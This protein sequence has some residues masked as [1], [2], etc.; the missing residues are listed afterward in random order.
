M[1]DLELDD[2]DDD[3]VD[4]CS[5]TSNLS[6]QNSINLNRR[7]RN[8]TVSEIINE[9]LREANL[10]E[11]DDASCASSTVSRI[12][13]KKRVRIRLSKNEYFN[14][15]TE[16][17]TTEEIDRA[18]WSVEDYDK[19]V[20]KTQD[21]IDA[22]SRLNKEPMQD[23]I[24]L[25][26]LCYKSDGES[27]DDLKRAVKLTPTVSRGFESD[28]IPPLKQSR[29]R[30][31]KAVLQLAQSSPHDEEAIAECSRALSRPHQMLAKAFAQRDVAAA[32]AAISSEW[33][34]RRSSQKHRD[35]Q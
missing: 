6:I 33:K 8:K 17:F 13:K 26:A 3:D 1:E 23:L 12:S 34:K 32:V 28:I 35:P 29:K 18:W 14:G 20:E 2:D 7:R 31:S 30:H 22:F 16:P 15:T 5:S 9:G 21:F 27:I 19:A 4:D 24:R 11:L 10:F 25:V